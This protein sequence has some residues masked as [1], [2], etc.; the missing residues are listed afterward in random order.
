MPK[1]KNNPFFGALEKNIRAATNDALIKSVVGDPHQTI[2]QILQSLGEQ[3]E[4]KYLLEAFHELQIG[5]IVQGAVAMAQAAH[6]QA[7]APTPAASSPRDDAPK[8]SAP[9]NG[10]PKNGTKKKSPPR[11]A[12]GESKPET[13]DLSSPDKLKAYEASIVKALKAGNHVDEKSGISSQN[14]RKIVGGDTEQARSTL[15]SLIESGRL[16]F[17]GKARGTKYYLFA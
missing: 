2:G 11:T 1:D 5:E 3:E 4:A 14:L 6:A 12:K 10:T 7:V 15:N 9:K 13:I 16:S 17:Y 8:A